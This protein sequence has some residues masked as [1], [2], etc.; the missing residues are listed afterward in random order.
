MGKNGRLSGKK[1]DIR[2]KWKR[3]T[4]GLMPL[5]LARTKIAQFIYESAFPVA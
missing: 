5:P 1:V 4:C 2:A 3:I